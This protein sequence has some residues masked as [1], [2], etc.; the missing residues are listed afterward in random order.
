MHLGNLTDLFVHE[1]QDLYT[2]EQ[3][4]TKALPKMAES[5]SNS[6]LKQA[7]Q[8]H[9]EVTKK[10]IDRLEQVLKSCNVSPG[11]VPCKAMEGIIK[12]GEELLQNKGD[13]DP[14]VLDAAL[15]AAAQRVEHYEMAGYG[16]VRTYANQLGQADAEKLLQ[17]TLDEEGETDHKLTDIAGK[18]NPK[19]KS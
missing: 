13:A 7:F 17:Q 11:G 2:A 4:I 19:A 3:H 8:D 10:Q 15:I 1:L 16:A 9:L 18:I 6:N 5:A 14:D 12:E